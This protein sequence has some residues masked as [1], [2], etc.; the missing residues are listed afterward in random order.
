[1]SPI[2]PELDFRRLRRLVSIETVLAR[3]GLLSNLRTRGGRL[4]GPCPIHGGDNPTAFVVDRQRNL[5]RCFTG[6][7]SG[8]DVVE[9]IRRLDHVG[10]AAAAVVLASHVGEPPPSLPAAVPDRRRPFR[11]YRTRLRLEP[12]HPFLANKGIRPEMAARFEVGAWS[13]HGMLAGCIGVRLHDAEGRPLGYA[14]RRLVPDDRGKWVFPRGLP[15]AQILYGFHHARPRLGQGLVVVEGP[16]D[17]LR[18]AQIGV[19][20]VALLGVSISQEQHR[21]L[22]AVSDLVVMFDGDPAGRRATETI[23]RRLGAMP[24]HLADGM[25]PDDLTDEQ[26]A[27]A[28]GQLL[29]L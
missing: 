18:L 14:G 7:A 10:Y 12:A 1:M 15:K 27:T 23:G 24:I 2:S 9:L 22:A 17:V 8:G 21:L 16:W 4:V 5:W 3:R 25:D 20:A 26:L 28:V 29:P 6:C 13:G 19:A 11:R